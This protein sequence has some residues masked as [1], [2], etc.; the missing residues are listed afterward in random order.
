MTGKFNEIEGLSD[1]RRLP[2]LGKIHLGIKRVSDKTKSEY[3]SATDYFVFESNPMGDLCKKAYGDKPREIA[4]ILPSD[5]IHNVFPQ[6]YKAYKTG[7]GLWCWGDGREARRVDESG[8]QKSIECLGADGCPIYA[9]KKCRRMGN[10]LVILPLVAADGVFQIDTSSRN[11]IIDLNSGIESIINLAKEHNKP[12]RFFPGLLRVVARQVSPEGKRKVIHSLVLTLAPYERLVELRGQM[13][14]LHAALSGD[15]PLALPPV[16][17][18]KYEEKDLIPESV[19]QA[20]ETYEGVEDAE[21]EEVTVPAKPMNDL[22]SEPP[23]GIPKDVQEAWDN[24][25]V[26]ALARGIDTWPKLAK[27]AAAALGAIPVEDINFKTMG[28]QA[29]REVWKHIN[30]ISVNE[31][32]AKKQGD[33]F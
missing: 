8:E 30:T 16:Q 28:K 10:L 20:E 22:I 26:Q 9:E 13:E 21:Y 33:L 17:Q 32:E 24:I 5:D 18:D 2:R 4:I 31:A 15:Q 6:S 29:L 19:Y 1:I 23:P 14:R 27:A 12:I 7:K 11:S 25:I 3:P